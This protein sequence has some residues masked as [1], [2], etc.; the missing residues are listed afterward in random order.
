[1]GVCT[2]EFQIHHRADLTQI[3]AEKDIVRELIFMEKHNFNIIEYTLCSNIF[4]KYFNVHIARIIYRKVRHLRAEAK[5]VFH[6]AMCGTSEFHYGFREVQ[7]QEGHFEEG[8]R[9][10]KRTEVV[11][12]MGKE[13]RVVFFSKV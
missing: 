6:K 13:A 1:M 2:Y 5:S 8:G 4:E 3:S 7:P 11:V 9:Q 10:L 12:P